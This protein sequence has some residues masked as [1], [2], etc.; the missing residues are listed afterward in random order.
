MFTKRANEH[1]TDLIQMTFHKNGKYYTLYVGFLYTSVC[2][3]VN[4][5]EYH[6]K[7]TQK[8]GKWSNG[9][10][11]LNIPN[12]SRQKLKTFAEVS[13]NPQSLGSPYF[14][15]QKR[16]QVL[17]ALLEGYDAIQDDKSLFKLIREVLELCTK[18]IEEIDKANLEKYDMQSFKQDAK[19][20]LKAIC[21]YN[22]LN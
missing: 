11:Y 2:V 16:L 13:E 20:F 3:F 12:E 10:W 15:V 1:F 14:T 5:D 19:A 4:F 8:Y 6:R 7:V 17:L 21:L 18:M 22:Y 9:N